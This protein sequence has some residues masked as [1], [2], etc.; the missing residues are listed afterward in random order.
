[1]NETLYHLF[2]ITGAF[3]IGIYLS[4]TF[5]WLYRKIVMRKN[6]KIFERLRNTEG[7]YEA[8]I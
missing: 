2:A 1:M 7:N 8:F 4:R 5:R 3:F 6:K